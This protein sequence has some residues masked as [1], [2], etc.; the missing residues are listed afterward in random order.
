[1]QHIEG[2]AYSEVPYDIYVNLEQGDAYNYWLSVYPD[3][4]LPSQW[5]WS[6]GTGG[7]GVSYQDDYLGTRKQLGVDMAFTIFGDPKSPIPEPGSLI[8]LGTALLALVGTLRR[9]LP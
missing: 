7:D 5:G 2:H 4:N 9:K 8:M 3:L 1:M 6:S